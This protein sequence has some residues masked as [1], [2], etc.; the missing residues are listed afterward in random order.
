[1]VTLTE[2][3]KEL[4]QR[5]GRLQ[6]LLDDAK[7]KGKKVDNLIEVINTCGKAQAI[8][9]LVGQSTQKKLEDHISS[10]VTT[11]LA[12]VFDDPYEFQVEFVLKRNKTECDLWFVRRGEKI[13]PIDAS[14]GG[15]VDVAALALRIAL[16]TLGKEPSRNTL[17]LDEPMK[18]LSKDMHARASAM[19]QHLAQQLNLQIIM[20]THSSELV[21]C[22]DKV[23]EVSQN[24]SGISTVRAN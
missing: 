2:Y 3:R 13:N 4:E 15:A 10:L 20:V 19:I 6:M 8:I 9:Q 5:K 7:S 18:H 24:K 22:A 17:V 1:M 14:G 23:F 21:E 11:A 12:A 16:W